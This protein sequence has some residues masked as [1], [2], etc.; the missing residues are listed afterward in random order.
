MGVTLVVFVVTVC[1][2]VQ[3]DVPHFH[4]KNW[5]YIKGAFMTIDR[6]Y[7][8]LF[9]FLHHRIGST[10]VVHHIDCTIPHYR[11]KK[12]TEAIKNTF[13]EHYLYDP[14]PIPEVTVYLIKLLTFFMR[15]VKVLQRCTCHFNMFDTNS[16]MNTGDVARVDQVHCGRGARQQV[17]LRAGQG[18]PRAPARYQRLSP[19][20]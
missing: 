9:D 7:G 2:G 5:N 11:A 15:K 12:A 4:G 10:H 8:K 16:E 1:S 3:V 13:P 19:Q 17:G 20:R 14:T 18:H 6:P